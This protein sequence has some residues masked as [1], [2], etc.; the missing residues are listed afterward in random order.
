MVGKSTFGR[1]LTAS[2]RYPSAPKSRIAVMTSVV[3]IG[4]RMNGSEICIEVLASRA[5]AY[6]FD[7]HARYQPKL[8]VG[9]HRF[10]RLNSA[11]N[12]R[13]P[14]DRARHFHGPLFD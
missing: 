7:L 5:A 4:R 6:G 14:S 13:V 10:A 3:M 2:E 1:S 8:A 12:Y 11:R 9:H